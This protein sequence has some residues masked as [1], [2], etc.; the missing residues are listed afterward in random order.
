MLGVVARLSKSTNELIV[1][2][3]VVVVVVAVVVA[4]Q[5]IYVYNVWVFKKHILM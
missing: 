3:V 4:Y 5:S 1:V 2:V